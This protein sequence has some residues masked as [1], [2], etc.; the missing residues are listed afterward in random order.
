MKS[1]QQNLTQ[2]KRFNGM[3][4]LSKALLFATT[5]ATAFSVNAGFQVSGTQLLDGNGNPFIMRGVNHAHAWYTNRTQQALADIASVEANSVRV[6]LSDG[7]QW[8]RTSAT[9]VANIIQWAKNNNLIAILEVHDVTGSGEQSSAGTLYNATSYWIDIASTLQGQEDYVIIN[10]ANEPFGNGVPESSWIDGH[11]QAIQRIRSAGLTHTLLIDAANWGQDW[12]EV[13]LNNASTVAAADSQNNTM[14]SVHMYEVY[15]DRAKIE[16]YVSNFLSTHNLPLIVGEFGADHYGN[17]V[18]EDSILAVAEQYNIGYL[19]WS[20]SGNSSEVASLD[21]TNNWNVNSLSTWGDRL[22]NGTNGIRAT[23][24]TA[25]VFNGGGMSSSS[26]VSSSSSS[27]ASST[28]SSSSSS[29]AGG[30]QC[31]W[32]GTLYPLCA[33]TQSGWGWEQNRS[34]VARSTCS[35]QPAPYGIV[36]GGTTSSSIPSSSSSAPSSSSTPASSSPSS[37]SPVSSSSSS[38][39]SGS[40]SCTYVVTNQWGNGF[41]GAIRITNNG[42]SAINGWNVSWNYTD[43]SRVTNS[44]NATVS[45]SNPY[46]ATAMGWNAAIQPGQTVEFGF[47]GTKNSAQASVPAVSGSVCN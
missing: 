5:L 41:T 46:S 2:T 21:I 26:S 34:C 42:N 32:Y 14:F 24:E 47:Q 30:E 18:D 33:T 20:W 28:P 16:G 11:I 8:T 29:A 37:S 27:I 35:S 23:A 13:M 9:E 25:T 39:A 36:G 45:G 12:Q 6:V 19:G 40:G 4:K 3:K 1:T 44:W 31:N 38:S 43:G 15:Q 22:I 10:I 17:N 7:Q